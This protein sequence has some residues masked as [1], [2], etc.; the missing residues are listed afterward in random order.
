V[1]IYAAVDQGLSDRIAAAIGHPSV[2]PLGVKP[3]AEALNFKH[4]INAGARLW[5]TPSQA[6]LKDISA[7]KRCDFFMIICCDELLIG[8]FCTYKKD[9]CSSAIWENFR[10]LVH[11][12]LRSQSLRKAEYYTIWTAAFAFD[13]FWTHVTIVV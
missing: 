10:L 6:A 4:N 9:I 8:C 3:A 5:D 12:K 11:T 1:S 13:L 2:Q 7:S